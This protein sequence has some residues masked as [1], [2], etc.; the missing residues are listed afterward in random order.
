MNGNYSYNLKRQLSR[1]GIDSLGMDLI[2]RLLQW[3]WCSGEGYGHEAP[4]WRQAGALSKGDFFSILIFGEG[5]MIDQDTFLSM[6]K[7]F[8]LEMSDSHLQ[9]LYTYV[10]KLFPDFK[11][12]EGMDLKETEPMQI[13]T[14]PVE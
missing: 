1:S 9:E 5:T 13:F 8:G 10:E 3:S 2:L 12:A 11:V 6:A 7:S 14:S 4:A